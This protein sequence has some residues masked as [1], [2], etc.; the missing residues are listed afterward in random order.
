MLEDGKELEVDAAQRAAGDSRL[1]L[2]VIY[3]R[4]GLLDEAE[5]EFRALLEENPAS[6]TAQK[7][8]RDVRAR[9]PHT[10]R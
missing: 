8:L 6:A 1:A 5:R 9:R 3:A 2:G 10:R 7:L 4:A